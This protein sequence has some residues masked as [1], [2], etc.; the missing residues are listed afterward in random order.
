MIGGE[1]GVGRSYSG[2][3]KGLQWVVERWVVV[4]ATV[5]GGRGYSGWWEGLECVV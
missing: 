5:G 2:W 3:W 4:G 1:V